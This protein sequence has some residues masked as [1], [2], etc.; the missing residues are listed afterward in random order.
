MIREP[1]QIKFGQHVRL[2]PSSVDMNLEFTVFRILVG[3]LQ[4]LRLASLQ[5]MLP[6]LWALSLMVPLSC[7]LLVQLSMH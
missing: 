5:A 6:S 3:R 7:H 2:L 4:A 1:N